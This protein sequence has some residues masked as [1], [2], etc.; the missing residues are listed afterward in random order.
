MLEDQRGK[1]LPS[2]KRKIRKRPI[3]Q[4]TLS[5]TR[6]TDKAKDGVS[7][8]N[9]LTGKSQA[10]FVRKQQT[11][12]EIELGNDETDIQ[13]M[14]KYLV[15]HP[16]EESQSLEDFWNKFRETVS[17]VHSIRAIF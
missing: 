13:A 5:C 4:N 3:G 14:V 2:R 17:A 10:D 8:D 1:W 16:M 7:P 15:D 9:K 6:I 12:S 11:A